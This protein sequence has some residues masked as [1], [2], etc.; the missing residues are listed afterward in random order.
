VGLIA[1]PHHNRL[2]P[3][4]PSLADA[5]LQRRRQSGLPSRV[6]NDYLGVYERGEVDGPGDDND[7]VEAGVTGVFQR[8]ADQRPATEGSEQLGSVTLE[9]P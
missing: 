7:L 1:E 8:P 4:A 2:V 5:H 3:T 9:A 6:L